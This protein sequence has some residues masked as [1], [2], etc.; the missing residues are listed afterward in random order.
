MYGQAFLLL[1]M[2]S[3]SDLTVYLFPFKF[4]LI[5]FPIHMLNMC[6]KPYVVTKK[7][8][9]NC[10]SN[11]DNRYL[12]PN[13]LSKPCFQ[14]P[15]TMILLSGSQKVTQIA[16]IFFSFV[17]NFPFIIQ[18]LIS[19]YLYQNKQLAVAQSAGSPRYEAEGRGFDSRWG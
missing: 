9:F 17:C 2:S 7:H 1:L 3:A 19:L 8:F 5:L 13:S 6:I 14:F 16:G 4:I 15:S 10:C 18:K 11:S 12:I